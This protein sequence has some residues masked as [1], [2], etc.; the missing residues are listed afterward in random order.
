MRL[1]TP[2]RD[3]LPTGPGSLSLENIKRKDWLLPSTVSDNSFGMQRALR[4]R[5][6]ICCISS[7][8]EAKLAI[9]YGAAA[10]GL[11]SHMPSGSGVISEERI[12][13]IAAK[14]PPSVASFLLT[15]QQDT[16][17]IIAQQRRCRTN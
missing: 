15:S 16:E 2:V 13:E 5:I 14:V 1:S 17:A 8:Q 12:A 10:L 6:K 11:V 7:L 3:V 9:E 4:S